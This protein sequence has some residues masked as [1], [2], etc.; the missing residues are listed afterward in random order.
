MPPRRGFR[1]KKTL[2]VVSFKGGK[3]VRKSK[4]SVPVCYSIQQ[5][6]DYSATASPLASTS[7]NDSSQQPYDELPVDFEEE[8]TGANKEAKVRK[9]KIKRR[10]KTYHIRKERLAASWLNVRNKL[11]SA[12]LTRHSLPVGQMCIIPKCEREACGRC[13]HCGPAQYLCEEH[14]NI[15]HA[16]GRSLHQPEIWKDERYIPYQFGECVWTTPH[17]HNHGYVRDIIAVDSYGLQHAIIV[18]C[19]E[20]EPEAITLI[21]NGFWP[22]TPKQPQ[23]AFDLGFMNLLQHLFLECRVS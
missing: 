4:L 17:N 3:A 15:V 8:P 12:L 5:A 13:L 20:H 10:L 11:V 7:S 23:V 9:I 16:G 18:K 1:Y 14:M 22:S 21:S 6:T 19:C 2:N